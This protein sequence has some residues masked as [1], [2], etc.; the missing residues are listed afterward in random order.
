MSDSDPDQQRQRGGPAVMAPDQA[1]RIESL[2][3][4]PARKDR[5]PAGA[6]AGRGAVAAPGCAAGV[7][8]DRP[9]AAPR[10]SPTTSRTCPIGL[11]TGADHILEPG[12]ADGVDKPRGNEGALLLGREGFDSRQSWLPNTSSARPPVMV[13]D[14][15][16]RFDGHQH[17]ATPLGCNCPL[18][19]NW[20][21]RCWV[22]PPPKP[23]STVT[24]TRRSPAS[25]G[26]GS[27]GGGS[28]RRGR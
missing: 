22:L 11:Q 4:P 28:A 25:L 5:R 23:S 1:L 15:V 13:A 8:G 12:A 26:C 2:Y 6:L 7:P 3:N 19:C 9:G 17:L 16:L 24:R 10:R 27:A 21:S 18:G 14:E 20:H